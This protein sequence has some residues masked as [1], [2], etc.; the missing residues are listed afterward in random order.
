ML[1][2]EQ[3]SSSWSIHVLRWP[4]GTRLAYRYFSVGSQVKARSARRLSFIL[5]IWPNH[6]NRLIMII[7]E[8]VD[9]RDLASTSSFVTLSRYEKRSIL[10]RQLVWKLSSFRCVDLFMVHVS[11]L[12]KTTDSTRALYN[13]HLRGILSC[14]LFQSFWKLANRCLLSASLTLIS[15]RSP[16]CKLTK[17]PEI[18]ESFYIFELHSISIV[19]ITGENARSSS[20]FFATVS[21]LVNSSAFHSCEF[22]SALLTSE[23]F[24]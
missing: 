11:E 6:F 19:D 20:L 2:L 13:L 1:F 10:R 22:P 16:C 21:W 8:S 18:L 4:P 12:Y 23:A 17:E 9:I 15:F 5:R 24:L 14:F 7:A 3:S